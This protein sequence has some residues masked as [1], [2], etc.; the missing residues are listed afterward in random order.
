MGLFSGGLGGLGKVAAVINPA[1]A[2]GAVTSAGDSILQSYA[3]RK[4]AQ[5]ANKYAY[6]AWQLQNEY[7][8]PLEQRQR[9]EEAGYNPNLWYTNG[10][11]GNA[12]TLAT[13]GYQ[14]ADFQLGKNALAGLAQ[15]QQIEAQKAGILNTQANTANVDV[16]RKISQHN[17]K[18]AQDHNLPVGQVEG[19]SK[20]LGEGAGPI[21]RDVGNTVHGLW[22]YVFPSSGSS[23]FINDWRKLGKFLKF[24][25]GNFRR[26]REQRRKR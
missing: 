11:T 18:Y 6:T 14:A 9:L 21:I 19:I 7:N 26:A 15:Y 24:E 25:N 5:K 1:M 13:T 2:I 10:N 12:G 4:A 3:N 16:Q 23:S 8:T 17:L 20:A 22:D